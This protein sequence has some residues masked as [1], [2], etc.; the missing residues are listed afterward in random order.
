MRRRLQKGSLRKVS[1][2]WVGQWWEDHHRRS[3]TL[4]RVP[5]MSELE[6]QRELASILAPINRRISVT[7][8]TFDGFVEYVYLP[9][10]ERKW[11]G[12]TLISNRDRIHHYLTSEFGSFMLTSFTRDQ[13]QAFLDRKSAVGLSFSTVDHLRWDLNQIFKFAVAEDVLLKNPA[14]YLFT[15]RETKRP[16]KFTP[17]WEELRRLFS[18]L[19]LRERLIYMLAFVAG[20]RPGEIFGLKW[21]HIG[22]NY[23][24]MVQRVYRGKVDS[25]KTVRSRRQAA[26]ADDLVSLIVQWRDLSFRSDPDAW[27]FPSERMT[28]PLSKENWWRRHAKPRLDPLGLSWINFQALRRAH[29]TLLRAAGEDPKVVADQLGHGIETNLNVYTTTPLERRRQAGN[30]LASTLRLM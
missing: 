19:E 5:E 27:L 3:R 20:M 2:A 25:P 12:S 7:P 11:K 21:T 13:L 16:S 22:D 6:A 1:E 17:S 8:R 4:G 9:F 26:L 30:K 15:P 23:V 28:T 14:E 10:Y 24:D 29:S 18:V